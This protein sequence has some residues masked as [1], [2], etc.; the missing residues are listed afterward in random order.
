MD[1]WA[2]GSGGDYR[3]LF[4]TYVKQEWAWAGTEAAPKEA[5]TQ[6]INGAGGNTKEVV[7]LHKPQPAQC[8]KLWRAASLLHKEVLPSTDPVPWEDGSEP[9][10][11]PSILLTRSRHS[12]T[13]GYR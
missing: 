10:P 9:T 1:H 6:T 8:I 11:V 13:R 2:Q 12:L 3:V 7:E 5:V 4:R